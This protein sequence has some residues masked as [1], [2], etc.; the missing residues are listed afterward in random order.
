MRLDRE[1]AY[2]T[3]KAGDEAPITVRL[4]LLDSGQW[5]PFTARLKFRSVAGRPTGT[6]GPGTPAPPP[7]PEAVEARAAARGAALLPPH[8]PRVSR[9]RAG[10][11]LG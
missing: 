5:I 1:K 4:D 8:A 6:G 3:R 2:F 9:L 10:H 11:R 7:R